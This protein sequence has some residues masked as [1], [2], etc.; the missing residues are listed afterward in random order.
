VLAGTPF[1]DKPFEAQD[2]PALRRPHLSSRER[3]LNAE[4]IFASFAAQ[5]SSCQSAKTSDVFRIDAW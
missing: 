5:S 3:E 4:I 2:K 1:Q